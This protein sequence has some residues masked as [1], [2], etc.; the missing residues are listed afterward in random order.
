MES[1]TS[2][3]HNKRLLRRENIKDEV[4]EEETGKSQRYQKRS[5]NQTRVPCR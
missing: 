5:R 1:I 4:E 3:V 2:Y